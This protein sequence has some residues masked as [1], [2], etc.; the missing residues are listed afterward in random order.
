LPA[1][2]DA[3]RLQEAITDE[4]SSDAASSPCDFVR[5]LRRASGGGK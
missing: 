3:I 2:R 1:V 5:K 4:C